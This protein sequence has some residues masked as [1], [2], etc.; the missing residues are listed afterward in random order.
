M[1]HVVEPS[2]LVGLHIED[3][4]SRGIVETLPGANAVT[5]LLDNGCA[6]WGIDGWVRVESEPE[7]TPSSEEEVTRST[8][9]HGRVPGM[10]SPDEDGD[11]CEVCGRPM[12]TSCNVCHGCEHDR[13]ERLRRGAYIG[14]S[15][16]EFFGAPPDRPVAGGAGF[17][18]EV[19][20]GDVEPGTA[21]RI[22]CLRARGMPCDHYGTTC[23]GRHGQTRMVDAERRLTDEE[24]RC[25][26]L[27][28]GGCCPASALEIVDEE[29]VEESRLFPGAKVRVNCL[30]MLEGHCSHGNCR[31]RHGRIYEIESER[32]TDYGYRVWNLVDAFGY[33]PEQALSLVDDE[34]RLEAA[35]GFSE[36]SEMSVATKKKAKK[37]KAKKSVNFV[38]TE[39]NIPQ[40][41]E[42]ILEKVREPRELKAAVKF[43]EKNEAATRH[44]E[45][46]AAAIQHFK[47]KD[48]DKYT[49]LANVC[50][51]IPAVF[52]DT[53]SIKHDELHRARKWIEENSVVMGKS[54]LITMQLMGTVKNF[55]KV[56]YRGR[57]NKIIAE[58]DDCFAKG[59]CFGPFHIHLWLDSGH[60]R[61]NALEPNIPPEQSKYM[62]H[63]HIDRDGGDICLG[64]GRDSFHRAARESRICDA[65]LIVRGVLNEY[66]RNPY[67][68]LGYWKKSAEACITCGSGEVMH[69]CRGCR[70]PLCKDHSFTCSGCGSTVCA[71]HVRKCRDC[72]RP[73]C[74]PCRRNDKVCGRCDDTTYNPTWMK[75]V[76]KFKEIVVP[77]GKA[78]KKPTSTESERLG[79]GFLK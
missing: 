41:V 78:R 65:L 10:Q 20:E 15:G 28:C 38:V 35:G 7:P 43:I 76:E 1:G 16:D 11:L 70:Q 79:G 77:V 42:A 63:P 53:N 2:T 64:A 24:E 47:N 33:C 32:A 26:I 44:I 21:V 3:P 6:A 12:C 74:G 30:Y 46:L 37:K 60:L 56:Q 71:D 29:E 57:D 17:A 27:D 54:D 31:S 73:L 25:W 51:L 48:E 49:H 52:R 40:V 61:L 22:N 59:I 45:E 36:E 4:S 67:H 58:T 8:H 34:A 19:V 18:P 5:V 9:P 66:G 14:E 50:R 55:R 69:K 72:D 23:E 68:D 75:E 39:E 13:S 62:V